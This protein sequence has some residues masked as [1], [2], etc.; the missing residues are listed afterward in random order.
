MTYLES[1]SHQP[2][3]TIFSHVLS[4]LSKEQ[5]FGKATTHAVSPVTEEDMVKCDTPPTGTERENPYLLVITASIG[6]LNLGPGGDTARRP[7][8]EGNVFPNPWMVATFAAP[9]RVVCYGGPTIK[10]L[11]E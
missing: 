2:Q 3:T 6:Q 4:L 5:E 1:T 7:T 10:E 8:A 9:T 11:N